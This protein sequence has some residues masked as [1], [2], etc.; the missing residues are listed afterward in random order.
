MYTSNSVQVGD[1]VLI[2][3]PAYVIGKVGV[4]CGLESSSDSPANTRWI[5]QIESENMVV[6]LTPDEFHRT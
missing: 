2:L 5:I 1:K 4:V 6:S 3:R